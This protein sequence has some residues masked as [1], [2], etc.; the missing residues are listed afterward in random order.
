MTD[1]TLESRLSALKPPMSHD[2]MAAVTARR[3]W[4]QICE[5]WL[6]TMRSYIGS[7]FGVGLAQPVLYLL[8]MGI[9][10]GV[11]VDQATDTDAVLGMSYLHFIAPALLLSA[12]LSSAME[13]NTFSIMSGFKWRETYFGPQVTPV[14]PVQ[15]AQGHVLGCTIRY[16]LSLT[17]Y[18]A[19][20]LAFGAVQGWAS[21][22]LLPL[23]V[24][25]AS[26][27]GLPVMAYASQITQDKG[28]FALMNRFIVLPMTL[29]SGTFFPLESMPVALQPL[30][31]ISPLWHGVSLSRAAITPLEI[32]VWLGVVHVAYL[33]LLCGVGWW[34]AR[35]HFNRRLVG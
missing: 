35:R 32:P 25:T 30:G 19:V 33:V 16:T 9:G 22:W 7:V 24:L 14:T 1:V 5:H 17:I 4:W 3:G 28:Q 27:V 13:E 11:V 26:A 20:L 2:E 31:W 15:I 6:R 21:L 29:F 18:L 10:L 23:G 34:F 8:A 12:A